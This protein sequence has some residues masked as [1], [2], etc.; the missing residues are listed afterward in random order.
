[1][2]IQPPAHNVRSRNVLH[3]CDEKTEK[4]L[5][6]FK[7]IANKSKAKY[8]SSVYGVIMIKQVKQRVL[9]FCLGWDLGPRGTESL[10]S[11]S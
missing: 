10:R 1:L 5:E 6:V 7:K 4:L 9:S 2:G 3:S 11:V 8:D